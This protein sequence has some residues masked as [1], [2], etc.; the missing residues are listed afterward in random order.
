MAEGSRRAFLLLGLAL[1]VPACASQTTAERAGSD[2]EISRNILWRFRK[3]AR[4]AEIRVVC[5]DR[6]ITLE[7]RVTDPKTA[8]DAIQIAL[9]ESRGGKVNSRL[10][11]RPR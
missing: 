3:E 4:F 1:L 5:E 9:A 8:A 7:G 10:D 6:V 11:V 2:Q